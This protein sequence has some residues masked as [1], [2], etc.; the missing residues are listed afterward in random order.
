MNF[1]IKRKLVFTSQCLQHIITTSSAAAMATAASL[2]FF[3]ITANTNFCSCL[4]FLHVFY[5]DQQYIYV[6]A[7]FW[8]K[9]PSEFTYQLVQFCPNFCIN[10]AYNVVLMRHIV[11]ACEPSPRVGAF[12]VPMI[13]TAM[14]M[15]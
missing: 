9:R 11:I 15:F 13:P 12:H 3:K 7:P 5:T 4:I 8:I 10:I 14:R 6:C 1:P 2:S